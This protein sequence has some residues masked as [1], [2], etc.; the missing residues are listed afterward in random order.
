MPSSVC[1]EPCGRAALHR[2]EELDAEQ[3]AFRHA[4]R[5]V[6]ALAEG[7]RLLRAHG[8]TRQAEVLEL[9]AREAAGWWPERAA[10]G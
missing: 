3:W 1:A 7:V 6:E 10:H 8:M 9:L 5:D 2:A 4:A